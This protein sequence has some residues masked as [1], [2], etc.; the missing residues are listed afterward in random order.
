MAIRTPYLDKIKKP[1]VLRAMSPGQLKAVARELRADMIDVV[2]RTGG[3]LGA[4][5]GVIEL[6]I[7]LHYLFDTPDDILVWDVGP[8]M[9]PAQ[10]PVRP[11]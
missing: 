8:S 11:P 5:L 2:S 7:A 3:H 10:D 4:G 9:L 6:T 1:A